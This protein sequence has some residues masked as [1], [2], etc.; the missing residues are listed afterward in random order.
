[1]VLRNT[2]QYFIWFTLI[3]SQVKTNAQNTAI[4]PNKAATEDVQLQITVYL[5][6]NYTF[7][8]DVLISESNL[9]FVNIE[10]LFKS[11]KIK[12]V[13]DINGFVGFI[14]DEDNP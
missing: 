13:P 11:L 2:L 5:K 8:A 14:G 12:S 9:L 6:G 3:F 7:E 4:A 10:D 1:M